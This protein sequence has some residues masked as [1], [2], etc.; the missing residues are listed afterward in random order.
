MIAFLTLIIRI[1]FVQAR[2][3]DA[4]ESYQHAIIRIACIPARQSFE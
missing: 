3:S 2:Q 4:W 1:V